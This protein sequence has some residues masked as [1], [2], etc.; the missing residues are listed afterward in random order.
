MQTNRIR[1]ERAK[2]IIKM[3]SEGYTQNSIAQAVGCH[4]NTVNRF[5]KKQIEMDYVD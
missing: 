3:W 5:L 2:K 1:P 4:R